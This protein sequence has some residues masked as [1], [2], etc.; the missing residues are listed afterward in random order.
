MKKKNRR[1]KPPA[2]F[3]KDR[4]QKESFFIDNL[5]VRI[6]FIIAMI[7]WNGLAPWEFECCFPGRL[8]STFLEGRLPFAAGFQLHS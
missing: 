7:S 4:L 1:L 5:L 6:D 8:T 2:S 3:L